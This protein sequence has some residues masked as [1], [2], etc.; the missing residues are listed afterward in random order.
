M[1]DTVVY[2]LVIYSIGCIV[3]TPLD[4]APASPNTGGPSFV[5]SSPRFG[6]ISH[7]QS[8][9]FDLSIT[10]T[11]PDVGMPNS[12]DVI[13]ARL[14]RVINNMPVWDLEEIQLNGADQN[15]PQQ[16]FGMFQS[17]Q[18]CTSL[19]LPSGSTTDLYVIVSDRQFKPATQIDTDGLSDTNHWELNCL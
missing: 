9:F 3:P 8:D 10:V 14:Y 2:A 17:A 16:R 6:L 18:R 5:A 15:N 4:R 13:W 11:D 19:N 7:A 1:S 12:Q